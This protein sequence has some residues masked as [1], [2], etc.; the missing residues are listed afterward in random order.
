VSAGDVITIGSSGFAANGNTVKIG[1]AVVTDLSS[2]D[3]KTIT[4]QAPAPAGV[5]F[6]RGIKI[7]LATVAKSRFRSVTGGQCVTSVRH[8]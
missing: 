1:S 2:S 3:G 4:F 7:Y 8:L 5:S 6:I